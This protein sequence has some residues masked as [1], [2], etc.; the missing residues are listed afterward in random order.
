M[1]NIFILSL[2]LATNLLSQAVKN[3]DYNDLNSSTKKLSIYQKLSSL[4]YLQSNI[5]HKVLIFS[6]NL[7]HSLKQWLKNDKNISAQEVIKEIKEEEDAYKFYSVVHLYDK[8]FKENIYLNT[9]DKNYIRI[10]FGIEENSK[11]KFSYLNNIRVNFKLPKTKES[12]YLVIGDD[13]DQDD[14]INNNATIDKSISVGIKYIFDTLDVFNVSIRAGLRGIHNPLIRLHMEYPILFKYILFR[15]VQYLEYSRE[16]RFKEETKFYFDYSLT[17]KND[18]IR[19]SLSRYTQTNIEGMNYF[20]QV[21][22]LNTIKYD[23]GFQLYTNLSGRTEL[24]GTEPI[25]AKYNIT[26][27]TGVHNYKSGIIWKQQFF[28]KYLFYELQPTVEFAEQYDY[29]PNYI[30][31]ANLE[32]YF[33]NF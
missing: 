9:T 19:L 17:D 8:F 20:T 10:R 24:T 13:E 18:L 6:S 25:N 12:L 21:S 15:P 3:I 26:P 30:F 1:K 14:I 16:N 29:N 27:N 22:Y 2:L 33:G 32:L 28:K 4:N 11:N 31:R 23:I 5:S 7:D